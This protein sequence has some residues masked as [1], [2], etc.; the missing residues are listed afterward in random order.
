MPRSRH[1]RSKT[2][3]AAGHGATATTPSGRDGGKNT[4]ATTAQGSIDY[5][6]L[7]RALDEAH[8]AVNDPLN[9]GMTE[10]EALAAGFIDMTESGEG[11][12]IMPCQPARKPTRRK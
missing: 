12:V 10:E 8:A 11:F 3:R 2:R 7:Q 4:H 5:E 9:P 1:L 6:A